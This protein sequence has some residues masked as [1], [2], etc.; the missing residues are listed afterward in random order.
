MRRVFPG[1]VILPDGNVPATVEFDDGS[2]RLYVVG[3][4]VGAWPRPE[5][6]FRPVDDGWELH[7]EGDSLVFLPER[8]SDFE[9]F[10]T[11]AD[12]P[13]AAGAPA[14]APPVSVEAPTIRPPRPVEAHRPA[15]GPLA[16]A[17]QATPLPR[18]GNQPPGLAVDEDVD[19]FF[20]AGLEGPPTSGSSSA[21]VRPAPPRPAPSP[22]APRAVAPTGKGTE[23]GAAATLPPAAPG[24]ADAT[25]AGDPAT[26]AGDFRVPPPRFAQL[27][28]EARDQRAPEER[29]KPAAEEAA[30]DASPTPLSDSEN[31]RQW[32]IVIG[33]GV[34]LV[35]T[36]AVAAWAIL[37]FLGG[38]EPEDAPGPEAAAETTLPPPTTTTTAPPPTTAATVPP[39]N[40]AAAAAFVEGWN[41]IAA[42]Y[43][44]HHLTIGGDALPISVAPVPAVHVVYDENGVLEM[45]MAP[46]GTGSN[47]DI[48]FAMGI[49]VAWADPSL[50][51]EG[52]RDVLGALGVDVG[53]PNVAD[54]GGTLSRNGVDY[55]IDVSND[56]I[57]F[58][59]QP[60]Q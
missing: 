58:R 39:E 18:A 31:L 60:G 2:V 1:A 27:L 46:K 19:E 57:R 16:E 30:E 38:R 45:T 20:A 48:L 23:T 53:N 36:L 40:A 34:V 55:S 14:V 33:G 25:A 24:D 35:A 51:P 4:A 10:V 37:S 11:G 9:A 44:Y 43:G 6:D 32:A 13:D 52:R 50:S 15:P 21:P 49:A 17:P 5:V 12:S 47:R 42:Q 28:R 41:S 56:V 29:T 54:M 22:S 8:A 3:D 26:P 59:V 7:A